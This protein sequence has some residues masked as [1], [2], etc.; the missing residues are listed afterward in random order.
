VGILVGDLEGGSFKI[1]TGVRLTVPYPD[2]TA[3]RI[4]TLPVDGNSKTAFFVVE[5]I[6]IYSVDAVTRLFAT[7]P[8]PVH[9]TPL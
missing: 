7:D 9:E 8:P 5:S 1:N 4:V 2:A 6:P 3:A